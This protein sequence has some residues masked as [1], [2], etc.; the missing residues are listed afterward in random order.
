MQLGIH[1]VQ[2]ALYR[3]VT[4]SHNMPFFP[5]PE[6]ELQKRV[7]CTCEDGTSG[8]YVYPECGSGYKLCRILAW[9]EC[10]KYS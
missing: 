10:C 4:I 7:P 6:D 2:R 3:L 1:R 8:I 5:F 9:G